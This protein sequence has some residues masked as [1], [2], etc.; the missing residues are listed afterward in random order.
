MI[1]LL[2]ACGVSISPEASSWGSRDNIP[3]CRTQG[4][5]RLE[6]FSVSVAVLHTIVSAPRRHGVLEVREV[7]ASEPLNTRDMTKTT[8][9][10]FT[11]NPDDS[12]SGE[13][14]GRQAI[15]DTALLGRAGR[16]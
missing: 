7:R 10:S 3:P 9:S 11:T 13:M 5:P 6:A 14:Y 16:Q 15:Q 1:K 8:L 4:E 2:N 12:C